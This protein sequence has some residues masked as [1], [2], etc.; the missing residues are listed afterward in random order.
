MTPNVLSSLQSE[1]DTLNIR[2]ALSRILEHEK[3]HREV[4]WA[5]FMRENRRRPL[6]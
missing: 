5:A 6:P 2:Q 3:K 4:D 1:L